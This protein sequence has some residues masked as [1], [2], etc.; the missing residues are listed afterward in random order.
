[1]PTMTHCT[2]PDVLLG[3]LAEPDCRA[4]L[5]LAPHGVDV[6]AVRRA[7]FRAEAAGRPTAAAK[8]FAF[9]I[10]WRQCLHAAES[11]LIEYPQPLEL[12]TEHLL[13]GIA[14]TPAK[15]G[16]GSRQRGRDVETLEAEV[17]RLSGHQPGRIALRDRGG[18]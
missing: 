18:G 4:A 12:A 7:V 6:A 8:N 1:M 14:A 15:F 11:L 5:L 9:P 3:L 13:L 10:A 16:V 2:R 17:H